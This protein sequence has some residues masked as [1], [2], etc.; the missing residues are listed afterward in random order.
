MVVEVGSVA[1]VFVESVL[2]LTAQPG[3]IPAMTARPT[4][5]LPS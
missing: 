4:P 3:V 1:S 2:G 5:N